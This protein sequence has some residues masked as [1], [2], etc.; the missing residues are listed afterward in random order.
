MNILL[1]EDEK[2]LSRALTAILTHNDY[3]VTAVYNGKDAVDKAFEESYDCMIFD[4]MMPVM[5]GITALKTLRDGGV[6]TPVLLLTAKSE[7]DDKVAGLD[8]GADDYLT[9]PFA[10][11]ELLARIRALTRRSVG[12]EPKELKFGNV[13]LDMMNQE[14][15]NENTVRLA[16]QEAKLMEYL[17]NNNGKELRTEDMFSNVWKDE[18]DVDIGVV[19]L[20]I[21]YLRNKL[22]A[23]DAD[24]EIDGEENGSFS[25]M[26]IAS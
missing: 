8:A 23:I 18:P 2:D 7:L 10:M 16:P 5:D 17:I 9:K 11:V 1:A 19:W 6:D 14:L 21:S 25:L 12:Y 20:Y 4:I 24:V 3:N 22:R 15:K 26:I 13:V